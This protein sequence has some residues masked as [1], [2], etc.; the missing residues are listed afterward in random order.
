MV[1]LTAS[2]PTALVNGDGPVPKSKRVEPVSVALN[3]SSGGIPVK[4]HSSMVN[5]PEGIGFA[6][7]EK[8]VDLSMQK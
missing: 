6:L 7:L 1:P 2:E 8:T 4:F 3:H 5:H